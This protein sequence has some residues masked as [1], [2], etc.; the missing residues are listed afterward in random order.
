MTSGDWAM[1]AMIYK[2]GIDSRMATFKETLPT[3]EEWF[4]GHLPQCRLILENENGQI[5]GFAALSKMRSL[6]AY[7]GFAELSIYIA[8]D[9]Q[10]QGGGLFLLQSLCEEAQK[11]GFWTLLSWI[12]L[13]NQPSV[14]LHEACGF[15]KV[16]IHEKAAQ[17]DGE[18]LDILVM[19]KRLSN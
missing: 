4:Q 3:Q 14:S 1:V 5:C 19:E 17:L 8:N 6:D 7:H 2:E 13:K 11:A 18:W 9:C 10:K 15:R 16:G 12:F